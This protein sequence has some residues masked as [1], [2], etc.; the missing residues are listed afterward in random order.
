MS[1]TEQQDIKRQPETLKPSST[2][3][4]KA[5]FI[6]DT[7]HYA[8]CGSSICSLQAT[9]VYA[10]ATGCGGTIIY[11]NKMGA[12]HRCANESKFKNED[13][14]KF[15]V[16]FGFPYNSRTPN[17]PPLEVYMA[18]FNNDNIQCSNAYFRVNYY[19]NAVRMD[20]IIDRIYILSKE[21]RE[22][23]KKKSGWFS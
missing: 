5:E 8:L 16:E 17:Q 1:D 9:Y 21:I 23:R 2:V 6:G 18:D 15:K 14:Y 12:R 3:L 22:V 4:E 19:L 13:V 11:Y 20:L 7:L 10:Y